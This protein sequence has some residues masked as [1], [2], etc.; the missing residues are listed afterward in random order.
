MKNKSQAG[1]NIRAII[2][3]YGEVLCAA[4]PSTFIGAMASMVNV[5]PE[6]FRVLYSAERQAYDRG[7]LSPEAY[8]A[9][10]AE[11]AGAVLSA[12]QVAQLRRTDVEM[13]SNVNPAMLRWVRD[14]RAHGV[15]TAVLS[16]MHEDMVCHAKHNFDWMADFDCLTLSSELRMVKPNA[17]I[18]RHTL[19][20]LGTA[21]Q[22]T[23]FLDDRE[24]NVRGA[25]AL[26]IQGIVMQSTDQLKA[27]LQA[28]GFAPLPA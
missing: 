15:R 11:A 26:G 17:D 16:N 9:R 19:Q 18:Y 27:E 5:A 14:L 2:F 28:I 13:W 8:W 24:G 20:C 22:E 3:D 4:P 6:R 12:E 10:L 23:L 1:P 7:D 25:Q 21:P